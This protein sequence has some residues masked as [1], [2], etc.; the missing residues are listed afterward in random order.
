MLAYVSAGQMT[1]FRLGNGKWEPSILDLQITFSGLTTAYDQ[2]YTYDDLNRLKSAEEKIGTTTN[3]KQT[4][5]IDEKVNTSTWVTTRK[6][7]LVF[8]RFLSLEAFKEPTRSRVQL[9]T[10]RSM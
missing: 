8:G 4:F 5:T 2:T 9:R 3:W 7:S 1:R 10:A 6:E